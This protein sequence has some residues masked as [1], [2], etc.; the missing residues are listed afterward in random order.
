MSDIWSNL[1]RVDPAYSKATS[2][3]LRKLKGG[4]VLV[5]S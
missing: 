1:P 3:T 5:A 4:K 2:A